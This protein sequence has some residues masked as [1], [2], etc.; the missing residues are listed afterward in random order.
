V[1]RRRATQINQGREQGRQAAADH[2]ASTSIWE[3]SVGALGFILV[4]ATIAF[5]A[6]QGLTTR[7][8]KTPSISTK[9][10]AVT[11]TSGGYLVRFRARNTGGG[12]AAALRIKGELRRDGNT[13]E[14]SEAILDYLPS[15]GEREGGL[16]FRE[17][18]NSY[19]LLVAPEGYADP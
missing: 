8:E 19:E 7:E 14:R 6:Y 12:T 9:V 15:S 10:T 1:N 5:L 13:I 2:A 16:I 18:P 4:L 17:N 11:P 3:A